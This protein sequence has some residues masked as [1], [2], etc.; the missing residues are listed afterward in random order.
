M[1]C[2]AGKKSPETLDYLLKRRSVLAKADAL[3]SPGPNTQELED[4]LTAASRVP[5]HG[6]ICPFYFMVFEGDARQKAGEII[7]QSYAKNNPDCR[8]GKVEVEADR[9]MRAPMVI[10]VIHRARESK[11]PLWEQMLSAGAACQNLILAANAL[12]FGAQW[13]TEWYAYDEDVRQ[14]LGLDGR[15]VVAGFIYLGSVD[16]T[17]EDRDRP[18]LN[19]IVNHWEHGADLKKGDCYARTKFDVPDLGFEIKLSE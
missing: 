7:A 8:E 3:K 19:E 4:I 9:F 14:G 15:D 16:E 5:D 17:P 1:S 12:G 18:D 10:G 13:L 11:N 2:V 6:K